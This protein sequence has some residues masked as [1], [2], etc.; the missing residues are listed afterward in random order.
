MKCSGHA[1]IYNQG[2]QTVKNEVLEA[3]ISEKVASGRM[4]I[5]R[6]TCVSRQQLPRLLV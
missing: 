5:V 4:S 6:L 3:K 1:R 2:M